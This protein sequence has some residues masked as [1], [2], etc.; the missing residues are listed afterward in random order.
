MHK[1]CFILLVLLLTGNYAKANRSI[2]DSTYNNRFIGVNYYSGILKFHHKEMEIMQENRASAFELSYVFVGNGNKLWHTYYKQPKFGLVYKFMDLGSYRILG[3]S[4]SI[5]PFINFPIYSPSKNIQFGLFVGPGLSYVTKIYH[6]TEN[7]KNSAISSHLNAYINLGATISY[8]ISNSIEIDGGFHMVHFSNGT[9]KKPNSGLNYSLLSVGLSYATG[10]AKLE[11][12]SNYSFLDKNSR[13]LLVGVGSYK[14][15][16]GAG[17]PKYGV[18]SFSV[19]YSRKIKPLW[20]YGFSWDLMYDGSNGFILERERVPWDNNWQL[21]K[22]GFT[23]NTE[24]ILDR[25]S[26]VFHFGGYIYNKNEPD[27]NGVVYQRIGLRY[28]TL[29]KMWLHLALK[30][31]WGSADYVELGIAYKI[32]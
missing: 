11:N 3:Y 22:S 4:H 28:R 25:L 6:R 32:L 15:V 9:F 8:K 23:L 27:N 18:G 10:N 26:A 17:G 2:V 12:G 29:D 1:F 16:K 19:E 31:H 20:W 13:L 21:L 30:T 7:F 5:Y 14:E 24:I